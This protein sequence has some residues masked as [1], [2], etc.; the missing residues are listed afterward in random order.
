MEE[1]RCTKVVGLELL[2]ARGVAYL[3]CDNYVVNKESILNQLKEG[4]SCL[5][6]QYFTLLLTCFNML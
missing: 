2:V 1:A 3:L 5:K 4:I 6:R